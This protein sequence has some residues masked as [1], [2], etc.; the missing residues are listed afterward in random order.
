VECVDEGDEWR[1]REIAN[2]IEAGERVFG[3]CLTVRIGND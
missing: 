2:R 3:N 1:G